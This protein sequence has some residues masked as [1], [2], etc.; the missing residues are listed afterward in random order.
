MV[1]G[2]TGGLGKIYCEKL[3]KSGENLYL[4]GRNAE[5]LQLL[6]N[7]LETKYRGVTVR[8][9]PCDLTRSEERE[10]LYSDF[11]SESGAEV[12]GLYYAAGADIQKAFSKYT[13]EKI[14]LQARVNFE[15]ALSATRFALERRNGALKILIVSSLC[16]ITPM[17]YFAEYAATKAA[18]ISF[19]TAL[20]YELK[21]TD[22][23]ITVVAPGSVPTR[24]DIIEDIKK[25]GLQGKLSSVKPEKVVEKSLRALK[26]NKRTCIAG[27]Y[28]NS[29]RFFSK[30]SPA[31]L[32]CRII[33]KKF[34]KKEKDAF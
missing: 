12:S 10:K 31:G 34:S 17:P 5:K 13:E 9:Y 26:K 28:N 1:F 3:A 8:I 14:V 19:Y 22:T 4:S 18:L 20:R 7:A 25:Q 32:S 30:L 23:A 21:G 15:A 24:K 11:L 27:F 33:A 16:G 29:V 2:A 6:K